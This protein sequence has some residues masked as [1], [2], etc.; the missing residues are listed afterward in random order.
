MKMTFRWYPDAHAVDLDY[1]RQIPGVTGIVGELPKPVGAVW[2]LDEILSLKRRVEEHGLA[3]EVIESVKVHE[4]IKLGLKSRDTYIA[5]YIETLQNLGKAGIKTVCYDFMPVFDWMRTETARRLPD[6]ST[7]LA[8]DPETISRTDPL[9]ADFALCDWEAVYS[10]DELARMFT[11]YEEV[12]EKGLWKNLEYFLK[13]VVLEAEKAG[14]RMAMHPDDPCWPVFGLPRII[15]GEKNIDRLLA[16]VDSPFNALTLCSGSLGCSAEN[17]LPRLVYKYAS[18]DRIAFGHVR[19]IKRL[20]DGGFEESAHFSRAGSL[21]VVAI[22]KAYHDAGYQG[23]L[24]PDHGRMIWGERGG[25]GYGLYDR[26]LGAMYLS[27]IWETLE[28]TQGIR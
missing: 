23:F 2:P 21:D 25:A 12:G 4:D 16:I 17:D 10:H 7:T 26:A 13:A 6:G 28:K 27:G 24:R 3:L 15:T 11:L 14:V 19:N 5:A 8:Y 22:M 20:P 18:M 1:I 9:Q